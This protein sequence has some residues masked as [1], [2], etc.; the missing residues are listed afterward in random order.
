MEEPVEWEKFQFFFAAILL[1]PISAHSDS[2][3]VPLCLV[4]AVVQRVAVV[5]LVSEPS[6]ASVMLGIY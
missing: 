2:G 4:A 3:M 1:S 6:A 5:P